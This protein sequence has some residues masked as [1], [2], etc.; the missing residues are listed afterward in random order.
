MKGPSLDAIRRFKEQQERKKQEDDEKKVKEKL[1][2]LEHRAA[3]GDR[4]AKQELKRIEKVREERSKIPELQ[5]ER[6]YDGQTKYVSKPNDASTTRATNS[7]QRRVETDFDELMRLAKSNNNQIRREDEPKNCAQS[8]KIVKKNPDDRDREKRSYPDVKI[9]PKD[10]KI[11]LNSKLKHDEKRKQFVDPRNLS[12]RLLHQ[13]T[14]S[15]RATCVPSQMIRKPLPPPPDRFARDYPVR[16]YNHA[17]D[18]DYDE[19]DYEQD[20][21]EQDDFVVDGDDEDVSDEVRRTIKSV[22]R[23]DK[24]RCDL[25]EEELDRQ[26]RSIGKVSTFEDLEREERRAS[27]LAAAEDAKEFRDEEERKRLKK[28]RLQRV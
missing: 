14:T 22:F 4:K 27:R 26:Y 25:R 24:R 7:K 11:V 13:A 2:T 19:D 1:S 23:Y 10:V 6:K 12:H 20:D 18:D 5:P 9:T 28:V 17:Y 16:R 3:Q 21:Y 15:K 8:S